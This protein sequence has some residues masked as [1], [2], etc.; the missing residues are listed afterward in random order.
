MGIF[1]WAYFIDIGN[2]WTW[3]ED[4]TRPGSKFQLSRLPSQIAVGSGLGLRFDFSF[5]LVRL[6]VGVK[7]FDPA[8]EDGQR[9]VLDDFTFNNSGNTNIRVRNQPVLNI[10]I[11]YPF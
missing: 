9:F 10:G 8:Q 5:L 7:V 2:S 1:S 6:D 11:G 4:Q 3:Y